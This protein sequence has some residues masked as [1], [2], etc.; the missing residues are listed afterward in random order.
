SIGDLIKDLDPADNLSEQL[1]G[2]D[3]EVSPRIRRETHPSQ[4]SF[5]SIATT[6]FL[7]SSLLLIS[8]LEIESKPLSPPFGRVATSK[9]YC[10]ATSHASLT[11]FMSRALF[12]R[13][14]TPRFFACSSISSS[15]TART[16]V[17]R[18]PFATRSVRWRDR[19]RGAERRVRIE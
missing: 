16:L 10:L 12:M 2:L 9:K 14:T 13:S 18:A 1:Q 6:T 5:S 11:F 4:L 19:S 8:R 17:V 15:S 3:L 7:P